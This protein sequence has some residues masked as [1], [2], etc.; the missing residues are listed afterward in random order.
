VV[1]ELYERRAVAFGTASVEALSGV[2]AP[3]SDPLTAD[4]RHVRALA[5]A[6][7]A[8]RGFQPTVVEVTRVDGAGEQVTLE[9]VDRWSGYEVVPADGGDGRPVPGRAEAPVRM[10]LVRTA[11]GWRIDSAARLR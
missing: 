2:Y 10:V 3:R 7:E 6:G 5:G 11:D 1:A 4:Q 9:L 8:L